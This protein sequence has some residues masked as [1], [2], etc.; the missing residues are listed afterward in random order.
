MVENKMPLWKKKAGGRDQTGLGRADGVVRSRPIGAVQS[1]LAVAAPF[2]LQRNG[3]SPVV[4]DRVAVF[5]MGSPL[6]SVWAGN[7][8]RGAE[9]DRAVSEVPKKYFQTVQKER[10]QELRWKIGT[11]NKAKSKNVSNLAHNSR[12]ARRKKLALQPLENK[13]VQKYFCSAENFP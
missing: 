4:R 6:L 10:N 7:C 2:G 13:E 8:G 3:R 1:F 12:R 5:P 9:A 11:E